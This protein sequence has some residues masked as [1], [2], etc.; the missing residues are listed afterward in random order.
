MRSISYKLRVAL[1]YFR[2]RF[3][4]PVFLSLSL[5][6]LLYVHG[7]VQGLSILQYV[8]VLG[9]LAVMRLY[10]DLY[11]ATADASKPSRI[12]THVR[13]QPSLYCIMAVASA[14][15]LVWVL[16]VEGLRPVSMLLTFMVINHLLYLALYTK[17]TAKFY[18]P[19][20]KYPV[21]CAFFYSIN[22]GYIDT[23][24]L[25]SCTAL[26]CAFV[27]FE[28]LEDACFPKH[29]YSTVIWLL[30]TYLLL[31]L[32]HHT[33][34][35]GWCCVGAVILTFFSIFRLKP[36]S[37]YIFMFLFLIVRLL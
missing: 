34:W 7:T 9:F 30:I 25:W 27:V 28:I 1:I 8:Q 29:R 23:S 15:L 5:L 6:L 3:K 31:W 37:P 26:F 2:Q 4:L 22:M 12:Y 19:L 17:G 13:F 32:T 24:L 36:Y 11:N 21:V 14:V 16:L 18:L 20:I 33:W 10:D 35:Y